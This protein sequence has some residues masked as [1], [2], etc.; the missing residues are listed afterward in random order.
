MLNSTFFKL[1]SNC[2]RGML[3][4]DII[5]TTFLKKNYK[6]LNNTEVKDF[7]LLLRKSDIIL[8]QWLIIGLVDDNK[9]KH[10]IKKIKNC[11]N[12]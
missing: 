10:L 12:Y 1:Y 4:L 6:T 7:H 11:N 8:Y 9:F 2:R 3:E 5:L